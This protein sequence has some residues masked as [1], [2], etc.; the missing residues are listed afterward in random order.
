MALRR[1]TAVVFI[2]AACTLGAAEAAKTTVAGTF[3]CRWNYNLY[4]G[5]RAG[6]ETGGENADCTGTP[7]TLTLAARLYRSQPGSHTWR[8]VRSPS[9]SW[10][11]PTGNRFV[12]FSEPCTPGRIRAVFT[13][14]LHDP[15]GRIVARNIV[16]TAPINDTGPGCRYVLR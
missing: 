16:T 9:R 4:V 2:V 14:A 6:Y 13:W 7:G 10:T 11:H 8:L 1:V 12:E 3:P 15:G 5:L